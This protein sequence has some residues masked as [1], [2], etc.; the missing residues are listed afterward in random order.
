MRCP[1]RLVVVE[2]ATHLFVEPGRLER[3]A[4]LSRAW[5]THH[6]EPLDRGTGGAR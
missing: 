6:L 5:F 4:E 3:V 2:G 1:T